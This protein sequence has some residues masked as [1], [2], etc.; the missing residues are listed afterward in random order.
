MV[1]AG[2]IIYLNNNSTVIYHFQIYSIQAF[3]N[4]RSRTQRCIQYLTRHLINRNSLHQ[5]AAAPSGS[6]MAID[7]PMSLSHIILTRIER[8]SIQ[9]ADTPVKI[10]W[11]EFLSQQYRRLIKQYFQ[12]FI[13]LDLIIDFLHTDRERTIWDFQNKRTTKLFRNLLI[14]VDIRFE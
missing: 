11:S 3:P 10:C 4:K 1:N 8:L 5:P 12:R 13:Q 2:I 6:I 9:N 14:R 7:L